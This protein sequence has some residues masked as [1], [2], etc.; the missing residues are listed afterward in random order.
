MPALSLPASHE[1]SFQWAIG[2]IKLRRPANLAGGQ[3]EDGIAGRPR[4]FLLASAAKM[5]GVFSPD[6]LARRELVWEALSD[7]FTGR[8]LQNDDYDAMARTIRDSG[9]SLGETESILRDEVAPVFA[10]NLSALAI[11]E[12]MGW[13]RDSIR[14]EILKYLKHGPSGLAQL[15]WFREQ[16]LNRVRTEWSELRGRL[17][18]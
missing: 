14:E 15:H 12:L 7:L 6:E 5:G 18:D 13:S 11:P 4:R 16:R 8:E 17:R 3:S 10:A 2:E 1:G 9:Y